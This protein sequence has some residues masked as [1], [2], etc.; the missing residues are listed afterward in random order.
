M[1]NKLVSV[2]IMQEYVSGTYSPVIPTK[3]PVMKFCSLV[4]TVID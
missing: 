2:L 4:V 1:I 3:N